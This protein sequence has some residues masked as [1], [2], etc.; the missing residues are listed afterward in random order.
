MLGLYLCTYTLSFS[1]KL[2]LFGNSLFKKK[3]LYLF[4][5]VRVRVTTIINNLIHWYSNFFLTWQNNFN[6]YFSKSSSTHFDKG[7]G[8]QWFRTKYRIRE[9]K[10]NINCISSD[11]NCSNQY[12]IIYIH[13]F[14]NKKIKQN[15]TF[16]KNGPSSIYFNKF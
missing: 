15:S 2:V 7:V 13:F 1:Q 14:F 9:T 5:T 8:F 10:K 11:H 4:Y 3:L 6:L 16:P 12:Q